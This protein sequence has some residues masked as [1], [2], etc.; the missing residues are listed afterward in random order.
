ML[1]GLSIDN[2]GIYDSST[3]N[4]SHYNAACTIVISTLAGE[5]RLDSIK[6]AD[7]SGT[8]LTVQAD[9][10]V[11]GEAVLGDNTGY[12]Q[13]NTMKTASDAYIKGV[14]LGSAS[15]GSI[16]D[17]EVQGLN[18]YNGAAGTTPGAIIKISDH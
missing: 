8:D 18:V 7:A 15:A 10:S 9:I 6:L 17:I 1:G 16:G 11:V 12:L 2:L 14:H 13:I 3:I 4:T 5:I